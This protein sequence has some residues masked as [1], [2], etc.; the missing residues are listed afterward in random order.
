MAY[1]RQVRLRRAHQQLLESD[2]TAET[3]A[4]V[5]KRWGFTNLA[6]FAAV[7]VTRYGE[8]PASALRRSTI[9]I[10]EAKPGSRN[11]P[12][13]PVD[14][15]SLSD[16]TTLPGLGEDLVRADLAN[17]RPERLSYAATSPGS[18]STV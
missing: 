14:A 2:T 17:L 8:S 7:Y 4:A 11:E 6:R 1:L 9:V 16:V 13:D 3:V 12:V 5:A 15:P 18:H 10:A